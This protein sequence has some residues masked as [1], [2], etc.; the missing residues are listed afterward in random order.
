M[1]EGVALLYFSDGLID[2]DPASHLRGPLADRFA[3]AERKPFRG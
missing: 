2:D 1:P 3:N